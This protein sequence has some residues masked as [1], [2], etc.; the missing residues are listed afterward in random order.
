[1]VYYNGNDDNY[2]QLKNSYI[3]GPLG[4]RV[5]DTFVSWSVTSRGPWTL[6]LFSFAN[7][8]DTEQGFGGDIWKKTK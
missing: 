6:Y 5:I 4:V 7:F 1:M 8:Y 2:H 3:Q